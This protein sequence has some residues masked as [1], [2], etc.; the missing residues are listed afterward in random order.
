[1]TNR[2]RKSSTDSSERVGRCAMSTGGFLPGAD[3]YL[4]APTE[5]PGAEAPGG[6]LLLG[7]ELDDEL[8]LDGDLDL[9]THRK[10]VHEDPHPFGLDIHPPRDQPLA[11]GLAGHDERRHLQR[12][13][14]H[15]DHVVLRDLERRDVDL[16]AVDE[17][18][19]V[20]DQLARVAARTGE[21][22]A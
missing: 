13:L 19:A 21:P 11:E 2:E 3:L 20:V 14:P 15:V 22:G 6:V 10:L 7:V 17:E 12:L 8:L 5:G 1:M 16:L 9:L 4:T 18:V